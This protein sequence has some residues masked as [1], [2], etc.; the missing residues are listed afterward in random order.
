MI[1][2]VYGEYGKKRAVLV[3]RTEMGSIVNGGSHLANLSAGISEE[4]ITSLDGKERA[5]HRIAHGQ[6]REAR[7][8]FDVGGEK[9]D[10]PLDPKGRADNVINC[11]CAV[12]GLP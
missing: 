7:E 8:P 4:W 10:Y 11:R 6:I 5:A 12:A 1:N 2:Q 9:L 3:A